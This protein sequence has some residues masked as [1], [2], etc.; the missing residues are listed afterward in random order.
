MWFI[1]ELDSRLPPKSK[2]VK[3]KQQPFHFSKSPSFFFGVAPGLFQI[4]M[5]ISDSIHFSVNDVFSF[6]MA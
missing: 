5:M 6:F 1:W 4:N 3:H 2:K